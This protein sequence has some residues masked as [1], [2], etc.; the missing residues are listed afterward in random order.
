M[1]RFL[2]VCTGET[3]DSLFEANI[4][5]I[6]LFSSTCNFKQFVL[7]VAMTVCALKREAVNSH[8]TA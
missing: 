8:L 3:D 6:D 2:T 1:L 5:W 7:L 4:T